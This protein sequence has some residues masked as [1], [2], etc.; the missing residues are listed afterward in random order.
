MPYLKEIFSSGNL[1]LSLMKAADLHKE[2][3]AQVFKSSEGEYKGKRT[4]GELKEKVKATCHGLKEIGFEPGGIVGIYASTCPEWNICDMAV[5][6]CGGAVAGIYTNDALRE[7]THKINDAEIDTV[8]V[9]SEIRLNKILSIP[10]GD[11]PTLKKIISFSKPQ[12]NIEDLRFHEYAEI[13]S[14]VP[15]DGECL[16]P[17]KSFDSNTL[18]KIVYTLGAD[19]IPRGAMLSHK[20]LVSNIVACSKILDFRDSDT[21]LCHLPTAHALQSVLANLTLISGGTLAYIDKKNFISDMRHIR[22]TIIPGVPKVFSRII[23]AAQN[24]AK[25]IINEQ[26][27]L[28]SEKLSTSDASTLINKL[29]LDRTRMCISGAAKLDPEV[30]TKLEYELDIPIL[31]GYGMSETSP[32]ISVNS[33]MERKPGTVGKPVPGLDVLIVDDEGIPVQPGL[34]GEITVRGD[35]VFSGYKNMQSYN[36]KIFSEDGY[37]Y[38]GDLGFFDHD[39]FLVIQGRKGSRVKFANGEYY[40][41]ESANKIFLKN[42]NLIGQVAIAGEQMEYSVALLALS[43]DLSAAEEYAAK[44]NIIYSDPYELVYNDRIIEAVKDEFM[45]IR[46]KAGNS[47]NMETPQKAIYLRPFSPLNREATATGQ[48]RM[49]KVLSKYSG[50]ISRLYDVDSDF[51]V[52]KMDRYDRG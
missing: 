41:L 43:E 49:K 15:E 26:F 40:D 21:C 6:C 1:A 52:L 18:A 30:A 42:C 22:P 51:V 34:L 28:G 20:N 35:S 38:T 45:A 9:D 33:F 17:G 3:I 24:E 50:D 37:F 46:E 29:G 44:I 36:K 11:I 14:T 48:V 7:I 39:G 4:Y 10:S 19:G 16:E 25:K 8:F 5:L 2:S 13:S 47:I 12:F 32:V 31:E 23:A 27:D